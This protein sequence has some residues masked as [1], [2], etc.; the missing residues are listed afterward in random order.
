[1]SKCKTVQDEKKILALSIR[2]KAGGK[3]IEKRVVK[4]TESTEK[5]GQSASSQD[6]PEVK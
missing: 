5:K 3:L 4:S 1:M 6:A 2:R